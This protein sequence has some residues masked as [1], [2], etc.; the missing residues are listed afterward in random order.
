MFRKQFWK[1]KINRALLAKAEDLA[2]RAGAIDNENLSTVHSWMLPDELM[3]Q[4]FELLLE[5]DPEPRRKNLHADESFQTDHNGAF[6]GHRYIQ[7]RFVDSRTTRYPRIFNTERV[8]QPTLASASRVCRRWMFAA[9][10]TLYRDVVL[11]RPEALDIFL[12]TLRDNADLRGCVRSMLYIPRAFV[13]EGDYQTKSSASTDSVH[14]IYALCP[15]ISFNKIITKQIGDG[16]A[17]PQMDTIRSM[18]NTL[19][20][21]EITN[22]SLDYINRCFPQF[23]MPVLQELLLTNCFMLYKGFVDTQSVET[24]K[25][26]YLFPWPSLPRLQRL[27]MRDCVVSHRFSFT[28]LPALLVFEFV[29]GTMI[30]LERFL[31]ALNSTSPALEHLTLAP[32]EV[33]DPY[34]DPLSCG[35]GQFTSLIYV[36]LD[37][38]T[39]VA[40][41]RKGLPPQI[42][43]IDIGEDANATEDQRQRATDYLKEIMRAAGQYRAVE[44]VCIAATRESFY[45]ECVALKEVSDWNVMVNIEFT[46]SKGM[47]YAHILAEV[48]ADLINIRRYMPQSSSVTSHTVYEKC[49]PC[50]SIGRFLIFFSS[51][52]IRPY[53]II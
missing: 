36:R 31:K 48:V 8:L 40:V 32:S 6:P 53:V 34:L 5:D 22:P 37:V 46:G 4:I 10:P 11:L 19:T 41:M 3:E 26:R 43:R 44:S 15:H 24:D 20:R 35:A 27:L 21:L 2:P 16:S 33:S 47:S 42:R 52:P 18:A 14:E 38:T 49:I 17:I 25:R 23:D 45:G 39:F 50:L 7:E 1:L 9:A 30:S 51:P 29:G 13:A 12:Q 28:F